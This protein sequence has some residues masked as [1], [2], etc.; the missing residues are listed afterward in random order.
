MN[1]HLSKIRT[2]APCQELV[3]QVLDLTLAA[4]HPVDAHFSQPT[5][6]EFIGTMDYDG[7]HHGVGGRRVV[8]MGKSSGVALARLGRSL[9]ARST[10]NTGKWCLVSA[11]RVRRHSALVA[12]VARLPK[13]DPLLAGSTTLSVE[14]VLGRK[15]MWPG[16]TSVVAVSRANRV[17][18]GG[19]SIRLHQ[20][21]CARHRGGQSDRAGLLRHV[22]ALPLLP[23]HDSVFQHHGR[24]R[25][26][27]RV[28]VPLVEPLAARPALV[29]ESFQGLSR[30]LTT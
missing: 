24:G 23:V 14:I 21:E 10:R 5:R 3:P 4:R 7:G 18:R 9:G 8:S 19:G 11:L 29:G 17:G 15:L 30:T 20:G 16:Q 28:D 13:L 12:L 6:H 25:G 1:I 26:K 27:V 22:A 2:P